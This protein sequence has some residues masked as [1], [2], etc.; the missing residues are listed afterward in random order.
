MYTLEQDVPTQVQDGID[1][2]LNLTQT[3]ENMYGSLRTQMATNKIIQGTQKLIEGLESQ[4]MCETLIDDEFVKEA[5]T[6]INRT[7]GAQTKEKQV[8]I[9]ECSNY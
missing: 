8:Y 9:E 6:E 7:N 3:N 2:Y 5:N 1:Y 4:K